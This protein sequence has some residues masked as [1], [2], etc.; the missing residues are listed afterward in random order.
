VRSVVFCLI[1]KVRV[2]ISFA[3]TFDNFDRILS[4][5]QITEKL[6]LGYLSPG[7]YI[8]I[9]GAVLDDSRLSP[10]GTVSFNLVFLNVYDAGEAYT[11]QEYRRWLEEA[12]FGHIERVI[13]PD[14]NS[15]IAAQKQG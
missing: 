1:P 11:E 10:P 7:G 5:Y 9:L 15:I 14:G 6:L 3:I 4:A 2:Q 12:G 8:Y 13:L